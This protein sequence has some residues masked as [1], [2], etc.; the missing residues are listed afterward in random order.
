M[1]WTR[2]GSEEDERQGVE[3]RNREEYG[4]A[5]GARRSLEEGL[6]IIGKNDNFVI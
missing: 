1:E 5:G 4:G 2:V 6:G 3:K